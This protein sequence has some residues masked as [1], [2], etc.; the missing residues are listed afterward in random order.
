MHEELGRMEQL[1]GN[2][3]PRGLEKWQ[4]GRGGGLMV[5]L[6]RTQTRRAPDAD[7]VGLW[8][9]RTVSGGDDDGGAGET[10]DVPAGV[11]K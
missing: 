5:A 2:H 4:S 10:R 3:S 6:A 11:D 8:G 1:D 7:G 9:R